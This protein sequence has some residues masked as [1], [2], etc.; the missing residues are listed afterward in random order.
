MLSIDRDIDNQLHNEHDTITDV[1]TLCAMLPV[2]DPTSYIH[3]HVI[4][5]HCDISRRVQD[6]A[7]VISGGGG[8]ERK[9]AGEIKS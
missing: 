3:I 6:L 2:I 7:W 5:V 9:M 4:G 8:G 1:P